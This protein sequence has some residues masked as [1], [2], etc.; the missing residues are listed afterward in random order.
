MVTLYEKEVGKERVG[1]IKSLLAAYPYLLRHHIRKGCLCNDD[2]DW[3]EDQYKLLLHEPSARIIDSRYEGDRASGGSCSLTAMNPPRP[4]WVDRRDMPWCLLDRGT[5]LNHLAKSQNRPLWVCDR[6]GREIMDVAYTPNYTSRER[7]SLLGSVDKLTNAVGECERIHQTAV[8]LNYAR[9]AL[10]GLTM[11]LFTLPFSLVKDLGLL[12]GPATAVIAWLLFGVYQ[13]GHSIED[14]FQ[15]SLRLS[16]LCD[17]IRR[18]ILDGTSGDDFTTRRASAFASEDDEEDIWKEEEEIG[19]I[20]STSFIPFPASAKA[21]KDLETV[22]S[23]SPSLVN[24]SGN[25]SVL[26]A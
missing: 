23:S 10:R 22:L 8:P 4:C 3:I 21:Q 25:W 13:I 14:P 12:T 11:W 19:G 9:H 26:G 1:R 2:K 7:L 16:M 6:L 17:G 20:D 15:G 5:T 24:E 18:D